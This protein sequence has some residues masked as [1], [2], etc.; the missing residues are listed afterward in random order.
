[1]KQM[2]ICSLILTIVLGLSLVFCFSGCAQ[3]LSPVPG[4]APALETAQTEAEKTTIILSVFQEHMGDTATVEVSLFEE[5]FY[6]IP[7]DDGIL[8]VA[9]KAKQ[10]DLKSLEAWDEI[11]TTFQDMSEGII[12]VLPDYM[13]AIVD[14]E[15]DDNILLGII[16]GRVVFDYVTK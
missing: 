1:M 5:T 16:N 11:T 10:G 9:Q 2:K 4:P 8:H 12:D 7:K 3:E 13:L 15:D 14:A 6:F